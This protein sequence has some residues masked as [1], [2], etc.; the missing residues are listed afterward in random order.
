MEIEAD[1]HALQA[2][3]LQSAGED[4]ENTFLD[5]LQDASNQIYLQWKDIQIETLG[6]APKKIILQKVS[7][8]A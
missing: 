4:S 1:K 6:I 2:P 3:L 7:G 8:E 5:S